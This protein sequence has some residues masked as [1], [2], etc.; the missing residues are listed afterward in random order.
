[1]TTIV[2]ERESIC[3]LGGLI[4]RWGIPRSDGQKWFTTG[5]DIGAFTTV[6]A[7]TESEEARRYKRVSAI[8]VPT[9]SRGVR[10]GPG[11]LGY[12]WAAERT[13][14]RTALFSP[15]RSSEC[16]KR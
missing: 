16:M 15:N 13:P 5:A 10:S 3:Q 4:R 2:A 6:F 12:S 1:L 14:S 8:L 11:R 7:R 9:D